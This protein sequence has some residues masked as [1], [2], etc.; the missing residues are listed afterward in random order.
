[1]MVIQKVDLLTWEEY[2]KYR[3]YIA[4]IGICAWWLKMTTS[5][6]GHYAPVVMTHDHAFFESSAENV[7]VLSG[8]RPAM[9]IEGS[10]AHYRA[11]DKI[12]LFALSWTILEVTRENQKARVLCD[13]VIA[14]RAYDKMSNDWEFS[15]LKKW[16]QEWCRYM[17]L[18]CEDAAF[19]LNVAGVS[20]LSEAQ[21]EEYKH[22]F[23]PLKDEW[24]L[25]DAGNG[26]A[27]ETKPRDL[28]KTVDQYGNVRKFGSLIGN[29]LAVRPVACIELESGHL[30]A[31]DPLRFLDCDWTVFDV[32]EGVNKLQAFVLCD[33]PLTHHQF[34]SKYNDF[35]TSELYG[36]LTGWCESQCDEIESINYKEE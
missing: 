24:W 3:D 8:V 32:Y 31:G 11:G 29:Q 2:Q 4:N 14:D 10:F 35:F 18:G 16:L 28:V 26:L 19:G 23:R 25:Q 13:E 21:Y 6:G 5:L 17:C 36:W 34:D 22:L 12:E 33:R 1:M 9:L 27:H 15:D 30:N 20:L 7:D